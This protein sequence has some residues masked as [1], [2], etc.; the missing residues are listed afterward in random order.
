MCKSIKQLLPLLAK[1]HVRESTTVARSS[2]TAPFARC[3]GRHGTMMET[4]WG[5]RKF[6]ELGRTAAVES[7]I[8]AVLTTPPLQVQSIVWDL[9]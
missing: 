2:G 6:P 7:L 4:P 5:V 8:T 3:A 1:H 9:R